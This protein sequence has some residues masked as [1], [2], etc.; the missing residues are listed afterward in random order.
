MPLRL[1]NRVSLILF[2]F[3][4]LPACLPA[5]SIGQGASTPSMVMDAQGN[6]LSLPVPQNEY[7]WNMLID[8]STFD[9]DGWNPV[10]PPGAFLVTGNTMFNYNG[11]NPLLSIFALTS[12]PA[13]SSAS[14][15]SRS[16]EAVAA[17]ELATWFLL[18]C[19]LIACISASA[20]RT[21]RCA[22]RTHAPSR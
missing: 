3:L 7:Y 20:L 2:C 13:G 6:Q 16:S 18:L 4:A 14:A 8:L 5:S 19:G 12:A 21:E 17:P 11:S 9:V 22:G 15:S 10:V 1:P